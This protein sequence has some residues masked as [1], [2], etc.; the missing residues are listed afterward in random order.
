M[1]QGQYEKLYN[2]LHNTI[3]KAKEDTSTAGK[4]SKLQKQVDNYSKRL[5]SKGV[6]TEVDDRNA[7][8]KFLNLD[9]NQGFLFDV[10]EVLGRPQQALFGG[11]EN[12]QNGKD[13]LEGA[14]QGLTGEKDTQFKKILTNAGMDDRKGKLD[15]SDVLG[16]AGDVFL[17]PVDLVPVAGF[18]KFGKALEKGDNVIDAAKNLKSG[19]DILMEGAIKGVKGGAKLADK[20][21]EKAL[22]KADNLSG[23]T[24]ATTKTNQ[25]ANLGKEIA[26]D[27]TKSVGKLE[28]YKDIKDTIG[29]KFNFNKNVPKEVANDLRAN[30]IG[31]AISAQ[32][33]NKVSDNLNNT[34]SSYAKK[35]AKETGENVDDVISK[36]NKDITFLKE[37]SRMYKDGKRL[38]SAKNII[39]EGLNGRLQ[40]KAIGKETL[41]KLEDIAKDVNDAAL[42]YKLTIK[43][44]N[45]ILEFNDGWKR[46]LSSDALDEGKLAEEL[47]VKSTLTNQQKHQLKLLQDKYNND[48][49]FK[50]MFDKVDKAFNEGNEILNKNLDV[51]LRT[52]NENLG[53]VRH[54]VN[55]ENYENFKKI[56][57]TDYTED[58]DKLGATGTVGNTK[59]LKSRELSGSIEEINNYYKGQIKSVF[60]DLDSEQ[61]VMAKKIMDEGIFKNGYTDAFSDYLEN[62]PRTVKNGK[63]FNSVMTKAA[64]GGPV[65]NYEDLD[66]IE[67]QLKAAINDSD[68]KLTKELYEQRAK[69]LDNSGIKLLSDIDSNIPLGYEKLSKEQVEKLAIKNKTLAHQ[70]GIPE[71]EK[72]SEYIMKN[73]SDVAINKELYRLIDISSDTKETKGIVRLYDKYLSTFKKYKVLSPTFQMNNIVGNMSNMYLA[74]INATDQARLYPKAVEAL[75]HGDEFVKLK[76]AGTKL[77]KEQD[78]IANIWTNFA[79]AGFGTDD[80]GKMTALELSEMPDSIKKYFNGEKS[81]KDM[82]KLEQVKDFL[83]Y[84]NN[85]M[86]QQFDTLS[87]LV[88]FIKGTESPSFLSRLNVKD[89]GEAVRKVLFDPNELTSFENDVMKRI[90]PFYTFTKKNLAF[91]IDNMSKNG[92]QYHKLLKGYN[93]LL[94][95]ATGDNRENVADWLKNNLYIPI[96]SLGKDGSYKVLR[97]QLPFGNLIDTIDDP[98][99]AATSLVTP[100]ARVPVELKT[101]VN[102]YT[103][104]KIESYPGERSNTTPLTK[105]QEYLLGNLTGLDA[106][107]KTGTRIYQGI[108]DTLSDANSN[109]SIADMVGGAMTNAT[110]LSQS[111]DNDKLTQMYDRLEKLENLVKQY[112]GNTNSKLPTIKELEASNT[113]TKVSNILKTVNKLNGVKS[114]PYKSLNNNIMK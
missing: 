112:E 59:Q 1:A 2:T 99:G 109:K 90:V 26:E 64:F 46:A 23:I 31:E 73:P 106:P 16:F 93:S 103:D 94:D 76:N 52:G 10:F 97:V 81:F 60:K 89:A 82:S 78:E 5:Q 42:D 83:P 101:G 21:I 104:R 49:E 108:Q 9:K 75:R 57:G 67:K 37:N 17:D 39:N 11:I 107:L 6:N 91:Q 86:N 8:E 45:G 92:S 102:S 35:V 55:T 40:A 15:L 88:T 51:A 69:L 53:Y 100:L 3:G 114:N 12:A 96:P 77:T 54:G 48:K 30:K 44:K 50:D 28:M 62:I 19:S 71:M 33:L 56:M 27:A 61:K 110:T 32:Q 41:N 74:G 113:N 24:Y 22:E 95:N 29:K 43:E 4:I 58:F 14:K 85:K 87:R 105:K 63:D 36:T 70:L 7:V 47:S 72:F 80:F 98:L 79:K 68:T 20:G 13:F 111:V 84:I 34:I 25:A 18:S 38:D 66:K 65:S